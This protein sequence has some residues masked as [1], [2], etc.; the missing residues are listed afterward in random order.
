MI[1]WWRRARLV[2]AWLVG[3]YL[4]RMYVEMG[5]IKFDPD[6]FW[7]E[8]FERWGY[9]GW[10]RIAVGLAEVAGG[11]A[12]VVPWFASYGA[13]LLAAVMAGAWVTRAGGG[14][15][16][17]VMWISVYLVA[18]AWIGLEWWTFRLRIR[19]RGRAAS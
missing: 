8:A 19:G 15:W 18:L 2:G 13:A 6:G 9:P 16:T 7:T 4:A 11:V 12:L 14:R 5:W 1:L 17:D 3:L 10:L